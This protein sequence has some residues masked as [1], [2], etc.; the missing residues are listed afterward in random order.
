MN[1]TKRSRVVPILTILIGVLLIGLAVFVGLSG[2]DLSPAATTTP[3]LSSQDVPR[4]SLEDAKA[5]FDSGEATFV[6]V[7][8]ADSYNYAHISGAINIPISELES[9]MDEI[10]MDNLIILY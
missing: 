4:I 9:R 8:D 6:D 1:K 10:P 7:R 2:E 5:A 3:P